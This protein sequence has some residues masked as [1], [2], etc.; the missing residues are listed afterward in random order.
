MWM[1]SLVLAAAL[2]AATFSPQVKATTPGDTGSDSVT[3][4][5]G[6]WC[7]KTT[8][9]YV[10]NAQGYWVIVSTVTIRYRMEAMPE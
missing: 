4:C 10:V 1:R 5:S 8:T 3:Y 7:T 9:T 6:G 2:A